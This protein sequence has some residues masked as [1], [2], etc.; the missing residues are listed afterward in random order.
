MIS[1]W[2][3]ESAPCRCA[4]PRQSAPVSPP[5]MITTCLPVAVI[6]GSSSSPSACRLPKGR[7]SIAKWMPVS[8]RPGA[9]RSRPIVA[10]PARTTASNSS[11]SCSTDRSPSAGPPTS[12][13][14]TNRGP[15][16]PGAGE[17]RGAR[18]PLLAQPPVHPG[19]LHLERGDAVG[20]H[21]ADPVGPLVHGDV[22]PGAGQL[23]RGGQAGRPGPDDGDL[24]AGALLRRPRRHQV[25]LERLVDDLPLDLL[26]R[27]RRLLQVEHAG[28]LARRRAQLPGE[29]R[30]VVGGVQPL[31]RLGPVVPAGQVVPLGDE[32]PERAAVVA[33]RDAAV[34][35]AGRLL[36]DVGEREDL[37]LPVLPGEV[38]VLP[39]QQ[40]QVD[41]APRRQLPLV[42]E[43]SG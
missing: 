3:T 15:A 4:V 38:D 33:E 18:A 13:P 36:P 8:S 12:T 34:H 2:V 37:V 11:R 40:P 43:K 19:L 27:D 10:P 26:D 6:G 35:A 1:S 32:V 14:V 22:V 17:D 7:Y 42:L 39:V 16:D 24:L 25:P 30:E 28:A 29:L 5:P 41:R 21:P 23:L 20:E 31:D 9:G